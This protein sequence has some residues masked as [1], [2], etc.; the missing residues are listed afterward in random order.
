MNRES[1]AGDVERTFGI[2]DL[3]NQAYFC[4]SGDAFVDTAAASKSGNLSDQVGG[5]DFMVFAP[6]LYLQESHQ[7]LVRRSP[8]AEDAHTAVRTRQSS[9]VR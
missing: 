2:L 8:H 9:A 3:C 1:A 7:L 6:H 5:H 4:E